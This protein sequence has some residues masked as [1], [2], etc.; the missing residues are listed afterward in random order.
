MSNVTKLCV[1]LIVLGAPAAA[2][3][4]DALPLSLIHI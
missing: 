2:F 1:S 3:A 4:T